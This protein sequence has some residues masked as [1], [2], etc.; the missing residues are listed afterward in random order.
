[1]GSKLPPLSLSHSPCSCAPLAACQLSAALSFPW[2]VVA[3]D[4]TNWDA[5][6]TRA[7][8]EVGLAK[9]VSQFSQY[10]PERSY[11][12]A[13]NLRNLAAK[14]REQS[15]TCMFSSVP[16]APYAARRPAGHRFA[17]QVAARK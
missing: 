9:V 12:D 3:T 2:S 13:D 17:L 4:L 8:P 11:M 15:T 6:K 1:M 5:P 16:E 14:A 7:H 10:H